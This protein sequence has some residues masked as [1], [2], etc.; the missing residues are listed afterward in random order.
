[1]SDVKSRNVVTS[2]ETETADINPRILIRI[3]RKNSSRA[4]GGPKHIRGFGF[5]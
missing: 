5:L 1:M 2:Q 3:M 4:S